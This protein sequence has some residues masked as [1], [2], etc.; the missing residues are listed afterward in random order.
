MTFQTIMI[1]CALTYIVPVL[2]F[3]GVH[4]YKVTHR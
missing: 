2:V 3:E 4:D 1:L